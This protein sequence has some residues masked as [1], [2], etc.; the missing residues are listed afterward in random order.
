MHYTCASEYLN[1]CV[2]FV[3]VEYYHCVALQ[4]PVLIKKKEKSAVL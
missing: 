1:I 4:M 2:V 3:C